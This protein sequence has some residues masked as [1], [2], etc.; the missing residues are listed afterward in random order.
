[1]DEKNDSFNENAAA[2]SNTDDKVNDIEEAVLANPSSDEQVEGGGDDEAQL[3][4]S[5]TPSSTTPPKYPPSCFTN[6]RGNLKAVAF[7]VRNPCLV[8]SLIIILCVVIAFLL[9]LLV[10][11]TADGS[12]FQMPTVADTPTH[13]PPNN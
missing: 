6:E 12:P 13:P 10:F 11:R 3:I 8:F 9:Q 5:G 7:V 4:K 2:T 1:M